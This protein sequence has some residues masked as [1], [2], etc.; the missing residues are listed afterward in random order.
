[1]GELRPSPVPSSFQGMGLG[2][3]LRTVAT[4]SQAW[5]RGGMKAALLLL[6]TLPSA[7]QAA[8]PRD[9]AAIL[10]PVIASQARI[11]GTPCVR[12]R[13]EGD[14]FADQ[15]GMAAHAAGA[16]GDASAP[17]YRWT[18]PSARPGEWA[19]KTALPPA[20]AR[21]LDAAARAILRAPASSPT[22][23][24]I[25]PS[26]LPRALQ[27]CGDERQRPFLTFFAPAV[28][29]DIAFVEAGHVCG[30]LCGNGLLYALRRSGSQ[31]RIVSVVFTW[32][33]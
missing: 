3:G 12:A 25:E 23:S 7:A 24:R 10:A 21:A 29:G 26:W 13:V 31:W 18:V 19:T 11:Y 4:R 30:G 6:L 1:M 33:S 27:L 8:P 15:R 16:K 5:Q 20:E 32:I 17:L 2:R 28:H 9:S 14:T 22:I